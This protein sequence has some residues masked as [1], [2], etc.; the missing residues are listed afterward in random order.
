M[1]FLKKAAASMSSKKSGE[2]KPADGAAP[3]QKEDYG[4]KGI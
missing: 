2:Q 4:D 3:A 1:D